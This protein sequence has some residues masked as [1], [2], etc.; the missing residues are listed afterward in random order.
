[1][2]IFGLKIDSMKGLK[3]S[4][5]LILNSVTITATRRV[6]DFS[7][8]CLVRMHYEVRSTASTGCNYYQIPG[9]EVTI[10]TINTTKT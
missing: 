5:V 6:V 9:D 10:N 4:N 1:M 2:L 8:I 7:G 3:S